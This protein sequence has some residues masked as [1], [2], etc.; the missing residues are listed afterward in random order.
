MCLLS[1]AVHVDIST[2]YSTDSFIFVLQRFISLRG[3]PSPIKI[4]SDRGS[5]LKSADREIKDV[6]LSID[7]KRIMEFGACH[8]FD[9][10]FCAPNAPWQNGCSEA[11]VK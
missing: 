2:D 11:L 7:D 3:C 6:L 10:E 1:R 9:W 5:Q 4:W 8:A